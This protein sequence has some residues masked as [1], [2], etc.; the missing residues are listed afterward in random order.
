MQLNKSQTKYSEL[1]KTTEKAWM[2]LCRK[3]KK[4]SK[5]V[6]PNHR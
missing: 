3:W 1:E 6:Q 2:Q 4:T 5:V